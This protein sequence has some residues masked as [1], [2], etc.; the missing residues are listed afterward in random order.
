MIDIDNILFGSEMVGAVRGI[1]P[2]TGHYFDDTKR[3]IDALRPRA[4]DDERRCSSGNARR[5]YPR[6]DAALT[7]RG[8]MSAHVRSPD[9]DWLAVRPVTRKPTVP[10]AA[11]R[12]R[13]ALPRVRSGRR[14][15]LRARAQVHAR[16]T[17][18]RSSSSRCA[19]YWV[20]TATSIVQATCH[21]TDNRAL[22]D[23]LRA[24]DGR[25]RGV[26]TVDRDVT[27]A[28]LEELHDAGV[29]GMR[30]NFVKRLV[31]LTP[32]RPT[33]ADR[34]PDRAARLARRRLLRG[35][36]PRRA[37]GPLHRRCRR[38]SSSTTW[39]GPT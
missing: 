20:S 32:G 22:V 11:G 7:A 27:D 13:R 10:A 1:D 38:P 37:L 16:A 5:V 34:A 9:A 21:G 39:A 35:C 24:P 15:P 28:E 4:A 26:A 31:D 29:R 30:F 6:L 18:R 19:T 36:R 8:L 17:H 33:T 23:A 25:A 12:R 3:Y 14:V 2:E